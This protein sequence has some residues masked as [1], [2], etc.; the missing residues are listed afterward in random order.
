MSLDQVTLPSTDVTA[1][2]GICE[3]LGLKIVVDAR[4]HYV[5]FECPDGRVRSR[6]T[7]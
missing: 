3:K 6:C 1:S 2:K 7:R 5:R 4:P